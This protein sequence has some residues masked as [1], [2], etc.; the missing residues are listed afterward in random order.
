MGC[1]ELEKLRTEAAEL[2]KELSDRRKTAH[3]HRQDDRSVA[4][5][6]TSD[7]EAFLQR[8]ILKKAGEIEQHLA[9]HNCQ[10]DS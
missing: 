10:H 8:R 5:R 4:H 1:P 7:F 9:I 6:A 2:R 3:K